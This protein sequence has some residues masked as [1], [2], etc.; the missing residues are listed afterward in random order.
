MGF[1]GRSSSWSK[2]GGL[3]NTAPPATVLMEDGLIGFAAKTKTRG[4]SE[5]RPWGSSRYAFSNEKRLQDGYGLFENE[6]VD[7]SLDCWIGHHPIIEYELGFPNHAHAFW[8]CADKMMTCLLLQSER[9]DGHGI[10]PHSLK[11]ATISTWA[12]EVIRGEANLPQLAIQGNYRADTAQDM[13]KVYS[14]NPTTT[15]LR[16][17]IRPG[18]FQWKQRRRVYRSGP[19]GIFGRMSTR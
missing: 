7:F 3:I 19:V 5:G 18:S 12:T 6:S 2:V 8:S 14:R 13:A 4:M 1:Q 10:R 15:D 17:K 9:P 11:V 16:L